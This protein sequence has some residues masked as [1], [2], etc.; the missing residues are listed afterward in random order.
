MN[1]CPLHRPVVLGGAEQLGR[2]D[3]GDL[4]QCR[5]SSCLA[6]RR[7]SRNR[8]GD[9]ILTALLA[10]PAPVQN[11]QLMNSI[12]ILNLSDVLRRMLGINGIPYSA[13]NG[14][15]ALPSGLPRC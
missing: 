11:G 14:P 9:E 7:E 4:W 6:G 3:E 10:P 12:P 15:V 2:Y 5:E 1:G 13:S 8:Q